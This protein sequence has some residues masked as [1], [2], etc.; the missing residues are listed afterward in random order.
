MPRSEA[1]GVALPEAR[2]ARE[3]RVG[4]L[5]HAAPAGDG[6]GFHPT[7]PGE[8][9]KQQGTQENG[10]SCAIIARQARRA[11]RGSRRPHDCLI[12][13]AATDPAPYVLQHA[14]ADPPSNAGALC[15]PCREPPGLARVGPGRLCLTPS[16]SRN[17]GRASQRHV[18]YLRS[19]RV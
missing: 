10:T 19:P 12:S 7:G 9:P 4:G 3:R 1:P 11:Q 13:S 17:H 8:S 15:R 14:P 16:V 2:P 6:A 5:S 18:F